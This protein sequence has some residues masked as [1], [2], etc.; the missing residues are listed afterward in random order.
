M[1]SAPWCQALPSRCLSRAGASRV[2]ALGVTAI[3]LLGFAK[4]NLMGPGIT[5]TVKK[6]WK[7]DPK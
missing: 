7:K 1:H 6:L 3:T 5:P 4:L 2:G